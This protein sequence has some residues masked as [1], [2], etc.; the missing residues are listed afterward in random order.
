MQ[1]FAVENQVE[2]FAK[3][4]SFETVYGIIGFRTGTLR[5]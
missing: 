1:V 5:N 2:L 3:K 4:K